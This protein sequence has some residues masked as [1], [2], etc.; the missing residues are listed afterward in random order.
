MQLLKLW[1]RFW[2]TVI[3]RGGIDALDRYIAIY[4]SMSPE[5]QA[6]N[7]EAL[8]SAQEYRA[9]LAAAL[10][11]ESDQNETNGTDSD[12]IAT[13]DP[14][15]NAGIETMAAAGTHT[16]TIHYQYPNGNHRTIGSETCTFSSPLYGG[17]GW[18]YTIPSHTKYQSKFPSGYEFDHVEYAWDGNNHGYVTEGQRINI[19]STG[20]AVYFVLRAADS[21]GGSGDGGNGGGN[22]GSGSGNQGSGS[23]SMRC[24][25]VYHSN[26]PGGTDYKQSYTYTK[27][28]S[29]NISNTGSTISL[30]SFANLG[31]SVPDGYS[32]KSTLWNTKPDGTGDKA[33][34]S[35]YCQN[36]KTY[37]LYAQYDPIEQPTYTYNLKFNGNGGTVNGQQVYTVTSPETTADS[38]GFSYVQPDARTGYEFLGWATSSGASQPNVSFPYTVNASTSGKTLYAVWRPINTVQITY[39]ANGGINPPASQELN[40]GSATYIA[41]QGAMTNGA[42]TF[43]G[44]SST[45]DGDVE[46]EPGDYITVNEDMTLYAVWNMPVEEVTLIYDANGGTNA[47][48]AVTVN[49][50][51]NVTLKNK[52]GMSHPE[53]LEFLGW[54]TN[55]DATVADAYW[56]DYGAVVPLNASTTLY[57]VWKPAIQY[58]RTTFNLNSSFAYGDANLEDLVMSGYSLD[59]EITNPNV[60]GFNL[61]GTLNASDAM[62]TTNGSDPAWQW[63]LTL[64]L[65]QSFKNAAAVSSSQDEALYGFN[66]MKLTANYTPVDGYVYAFAGSEALTAARANPN[67]VT[68]TIVVAGTT[69]GQTNYVF[70]GYAVPQKATHT[71]YDEITK[72]TKNGEQTKEVYSSGNNAVVYSGDT[73]WRSLKN[74]YPSYSGK[75]YICVSKPSDFTVRVNT[76]PFQFDYVRAITVTWQQTDGTQ[77]KQETIPNGADYDDLYPTDPSTTGSWGEPTKDVDGNVTI[78]W[79]EPVIHKV[80]VD[81][82]NGDNTTTSSVDDGDSFTVPTAPA[83]T[84][85]GKE[86]DKWTDENGT[87]YQPGEVIENITGDITITAQWKDKTY[88]VTFDS[89]GGT[90]V[91]DRIVIHGQQAT[92]PDDPVRDSYTFNGW[93]LGNESYDFATPVIQDITLVAQWIENQFTVTWVNGYDGTEL[94]SESYG[95]VTEADAYENEYPADPTR[96]GYTFTGWSDPAFGEDGNITIAAQWAVDRNRNDIPDDEEYRTVTYRDGVDESIF[97]DQTYSELLDGDATPAFVDEDGNEITP[98]RDGYT[99]EGWTPEVTDTVTGSVVYVAQWSEVAPVPP[100]PEDP[101][102]IDPNPTP[103][104]DDPATPTDPVGPITPGTNDPATPTNPT[105]PTTPDATAPTPAS[106]P[107][108]PATPAAAP[109]AAVTPAADEGTA[110]ADNENPLATATADQEIVDDENPLAA[111]DEPQCWVHWWMLLGIVVTLVYGV[112]V[113]AHRKKS[114]DDFNDIEKGIIGEEQKSTSTVTVRPASVYNH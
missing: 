85:E 61:T 110:I 30:E 54:S 9:T 29:Y 93:D 108:T 8:A 41:G 26:Y 51:E 15:L 92:E 68:T 75:Q 10:N 99:F 84:P 28:A 52:Q 16:I 6:N 34:S 50:G 104:T 107:A 18:G 76:V 14:N 3:F 102:P 74:E 1:V 17:D 39:D 7:A 19:Y 60:P 95:V 35:L 46:F 22:N 73:A 69:S 37:H 40:P 33:N 89:Q 98:T 59:Y 109:A 72:A 66:Q 13:A 25:I 65:P 63:T 32:L 103:G 43:L 55:P 2:K 64:D 5:D 38:Y 44:W 105:A 71:Y 101:T 77:I 58:V 97:D 42:G 4:N 100:T 27:S 87:E 20:M 45:E 91:D 82:N 12:G 112:G 78:K 86:F 24:T 70:N 56:S 11:A 90:R 31:F 94:K 47:P 83:N 106:G 80:T 57:A 48:S 49:K 81:P 88:T 96:D 79:T 113:L 23:Y 62:K 53:G 114:Y 111:F 21:G 36:G 67:N